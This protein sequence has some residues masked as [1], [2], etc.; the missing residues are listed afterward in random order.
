MVIEGELKKIALPEVFVRE[1]KSCFYDTFR[2]KLIEI[3]PE[4]TVRQRVAGFFV[5]KLHVPKDY[6]WLEVP[7]SYY[8]EGQR[9]RADIIIHERNQE[10]GLLHP[11]TVIE[12]KNEDVYLTAQVVEQAIGYCD[13]IG[14]KYI[15]VTNGIDMEFAVYNEDTD[16]YDFLDKMLD[17]S[18]MVEGNFQIA[19]KE[20]TF[21][22]RFSLKE[23][24]D[25][26]LLEQFNYEEEVWCYG[27]DTPSALK[28]YIVNLYQGLMDEEHKLTPTKKKN[29]ELLEDLGVSYLDY[30]NAGGGHYV[31]FYRS[32]L[33][34]DRK[35]DAQIINISIFGTA[36]DFKG[37]HRNSYA[38]LVVSIDRFKTSHNTLQYNI[39]RYGHI[40]DGSLHFLH[41]GQISNHKAKDVVDYISVHGD[42]IQV[43]GDRIDF[44]YL[45]E[46]KLYYLDEQETA[47][48]IY[49]LIE[50]G[51][52][53]EEMRREKKK[54]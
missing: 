38:S 2:K 15:V 43:T 18:E 30:S 35:Q 17:Y 1:G 16:T 54:G 46:G 8:L 9:G 45:P 48:F 5:D 13:N 4:E 19:E 52:L 29:Y 14:A 21:Y 7:I 11:L 3:T 51:L 44:G 49:A 40:E 42:A 12:C 37:E 31:G 23:L 20:E 24:S 50:Y 27:D 32:F 34:K 41:N 6:L 25:E 22:K 10:D 39:D 33:I 28:P 47:D 36:G 26:T 53:R